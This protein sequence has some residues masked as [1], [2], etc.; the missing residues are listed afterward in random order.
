MDSSRTG[1]KVIDFISSK[2]GPRSTNRPHRS[3]TPARTP[4]RTPPPLPPRS[5]KSVSPPSSPASSQ[6]RK[7][8]STVKGGGVQCA[9]SGHNKAKE[10]KQAIEDGSW[11]SEGAGPKKKELQLRVFAGTWN[12]AGKLLEAGERG[13]Q[14]LL[15]W[16]DADRQLEG[17]AKHFPDLFA[18]GLQ[19]VVELNAHTVVLDSILDTKSKANTKIWSTALREA[20][21][22]YGAKHGQ[23]YRMVT[24]Q[25]LLGIYMAVFVTETLLPH[26]SGVQR[27]FVATGVGGRLGNKGAVTVR[28]TL[29]KETS[30]CF[31]CSH[32]AAHREQ[33]TARNEDYRLIVEKKVFLDPAILGNASSGHGS[34]EEMMGGLVWLQGQGAQGKATDELEPTHTVLQHDVVIWLGDLN[35]RIRERVEISAVMD[36]LNDDK[37]EYLRELDQLNIERGA[38]NA[39]EVF[40]EGP[41]C[42]PPTYKY[43]PGT[44]QLENRP[45]KKLRCPSWCDRVLW[46]VGSY[47]G[48]SINRFGLARYWSS[49]PLLSDHLPVSAM[50][51]GSLYYSDAQREQKKVY[52]RLITEWD[53]WQQQTKRLELEAAPPAL[54]ARGLDAGS[55]MELTVTLF[56]TG[57]KPLPYHICE[58]SRPQW[59]RLVSGV[60]GVVLA[61]Q[62]ACIEVELDA[63]TVAPGDHAGGVLVVSLDGSSPAQS[64]V[65][66]VVCSV[67]E[68][69]LAA[70]LV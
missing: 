30:M 23:R 4:H 19:E 38:G 68:K 39:F 28:M 43:I 67:K 56:N 15:E 26:I 22:K 69:T 44:R 53:T 8:A 16:L 10:W 61:G 14:S 59:L 9:C 58:S 3:L 7:P 36:M 33:V 34:Q 60:T 18:I 40:Y 13:V 24:E 47:G 45:E 48:Q 70:I 57:A 52:D 1:R 27:G 42:F 49:G 35:Y 12:V 6:T 25:R 20:V 29:A 65:V 41:L 51:D 55:T 37:I 63:S 2:K 5:C 54:T 21:N 11:G 50:F 31:V 66:P 32:L 64:L 17:T 62:E 46:S